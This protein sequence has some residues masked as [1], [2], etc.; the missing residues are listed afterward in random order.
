MGDQQSEV[1][2]DPMTQTRSRVS[3]K[4]GALETQVAGTVHSTRD[5]V[6]DA[7]GAVTETIRT[8]SDTLDLPA[9]VQRHPWLVFGGS[10]ALGVLAAQVL[11]GSAGSAIVEKA[12][13]A[14]RTQLNNDPG[15]SPQSGETPVGTANWLDGQLGQLKT[16]AI[17]ALTN[18]VRD[19]TS[20]GLATG[21]KSPTSGNT[22]AANPPGNSPA[23][24]ATDD[25][26][27]L[28]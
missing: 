28:M 11:K 18:Y 13:A 4:L 23:K 17:A 9:Q 15:A 5:A 20:N 24:I 21:G 1:M 10:V 25:R 16:M 3:E 8:V 7:V 6:G 19:M 14:L 27:G 22:H 26:E 2:H 12:A